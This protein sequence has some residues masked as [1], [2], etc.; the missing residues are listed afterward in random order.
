MSGILCSSLQAHPCPSSHQQHPET[1]G[2]QSGMRKEGKV[3]LCMSLCPES[4]MQQC[5][6]SQRGGQTHLKQGFPFPSQDVHDAAGVIHHFTCLSPAADTAPPLGEQ[7]LQSC[8]PVQGE[9]RTRT[10]LSSLTGLQS[11]KLLISR[12]LLP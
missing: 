5:K 4:G 9:D 7:T 10:F 3:S 2:Q 1:R 12:F 8:C 6:R 11:P